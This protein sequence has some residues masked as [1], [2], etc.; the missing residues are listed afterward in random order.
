MKLQLNSVPAQRSS[1][2]RKGLSVLATMSLVLLATFLPACDIIGNDSVEEV[3]DPEVKHLQDAIAAEG[4]WQQDAYPVII[5]LQGGGKCS[6]E[7]RD[8][9]TGE[10]L[11]YVCGGEDKGS[12]WGPVLVP[13]PALSDK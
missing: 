2:A 3:A 9:E 7:L 5:I 6:C 12:A 8:P 13:Q 4:G 10:C 11:L 1:F